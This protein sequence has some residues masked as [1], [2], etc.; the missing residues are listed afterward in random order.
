M[1]PPTHPQPTFRFR[2]SHDSINFVL[3]SSAITCAGTDDWACRDGLGKRG[4][5]G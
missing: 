5:P 4:V 1:N 3:A 2:A